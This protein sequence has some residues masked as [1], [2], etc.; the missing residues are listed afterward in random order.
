M[1]LFVYGTLK[2]GY[3]N[4]RIL[5]GAKFLGEAISHSPYL[6]H[7]CGFPKAVPSEEGLPIMGEIFE[8]SVPQLARCDM[9]EGHPN[10]YT[11]RVISATTK[12]GET[13]SVMIYE[14]DDPQTAPLCPKVDDM[15]YQWG[16]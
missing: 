12:E 5:E 9:L 13:H 3:G 8:V 14:M 1:K 15:Y 16:G 7:N 10:W 6:L 11:R 2:R 4:N